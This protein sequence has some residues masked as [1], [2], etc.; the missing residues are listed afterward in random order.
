MPPPFVVPLLV[1]WL[2]LCLTLRPPPPI[3]T[4]PSATTCHNPLV[5]LVCRIARR[6]S[7]SCG[8]LLCCHLSCCC[9]QCICASQSRQCLV[10][11]ANCHRSLCQICPIQRL[12]PQGVDPSREGVQ[13]DD[14]QCLLGNTSGVGRAKEPVVRASCDKVDQRAFFFRESNCLSMNA[15][16]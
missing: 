5:W 10:S 7:L 14:M 6:L 9:I 1:C 3:A 15:R 16:L 12:L 13:V 11:S 4:P 8:W 2:S